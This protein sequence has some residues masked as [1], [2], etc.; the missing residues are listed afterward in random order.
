MTLGSG[1]RK[2]IHITE[3]A[4]SAINK[5]GTVA[6]FAL[7]TACG[8]TADGVAK[9]A[10][11][12]AEKTA[13]VAADAGTATAAAKQTADVKTALTA[14]TRID[15]SEINVDTNGDTKTVTLNGTVATEEQKT[16]AADIARP[17]AEGYTIVNN[18]TVRK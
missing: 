11:N 5:L 16:L 17:K 4:M 13:E 18:L 2:R 7:L 12:A 6:L 14:D 15:A 10:E 3:I 9:D 8:N 1:N